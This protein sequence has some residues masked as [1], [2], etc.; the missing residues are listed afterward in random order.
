MSGWEPPRAG[1]ES[2]VSFSPREVPGVWWKRRYRRL[3]V[4]TWGVGGVIAFGVIGSAFDQP[5]S[6][7]G[8]IEG[9]RASMA[10]VT[11]T[12]VPEPSQAQTTV[13]A[14]T[15]AVTT[16]PV[17]TQAPAPVITQPPVT[18]PPTT[19]Q[20]PATTLPSTTTQPPT[21][22]TQPPPPSP[23]PTTVAVQQFLPANDCD[24]N[25]SGCV[26]IAS[27][28]DCAGGK[29]NGPA[30]VQGPVRVIGSDIYGLDRDGNGVG[31]E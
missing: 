28:V 19:T 20:A 17:P 2:Q 13:P 5:T 6:D 27:D 22:T 29:G 21:T 4:W 11:A 16:M 1:G 3:P 25:Y 24:P 8:A 23:P 30:Y 9:E 12:D 10:V 15:E 7:A 26:P 31:C 14:P 18:L